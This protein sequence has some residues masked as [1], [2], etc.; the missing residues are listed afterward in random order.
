MRIPI[1]HEPDPEIERT[2]RLRRN[3]QRIEEQRLETR[4]NSNMEEGD[5][6][7]TVRDFFTL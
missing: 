2:F 5:Q 7:R 1:L 4:R 6:W 3:K